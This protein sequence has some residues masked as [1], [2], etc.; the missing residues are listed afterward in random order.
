MAH[1]WDRP[2]TTSLSPSYKVLGQ[3]GLQ[4][5]LSIFDFCCLFFVSLWTSCCP[6]TPFIDQEGLELTESCLGCATSAQLWVSKTPKKKKGKYPTKF[7]S[8]NENPSPGTNEKR[9]VRTK[10]L[11]KWFLV[12]IGTLATVHIMSEEVSNTWKLWGNSFLLPFW[13]LGK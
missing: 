4:E 10:L 12:S 11:K 8:S 6:G 5:S 1:T 9:L 7:S 13:R 2:I 3:F